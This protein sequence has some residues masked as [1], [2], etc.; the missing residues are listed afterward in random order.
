MQSV[1]RCGRRLRERYVELLNHRERLAQLLAEARG[2]RTELG[3]QLLFRR[4]LHLLAADDFAGHGIDRF[5]REDV[6][7]AERCDRS[8]DERLDLFTPRHLTGER[9]RDALVG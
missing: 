3:Q 4:Y 9:S 2:R 1:E 8:G 7:A 5:Q 6:V